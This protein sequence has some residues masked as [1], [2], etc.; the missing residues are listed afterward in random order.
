MGKYVADHYRWRLLRGSFVHMQQELGMVLHHCKVWHVTFQS[1][2]AGQKS[3]VGGDGGDSSTA[4]L[5]LVTGKRLLG[6]FRD[7]GEVA[8]GN[9]SV[10]IWPP[11]KDEMR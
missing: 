10:E 11:L 4:V 3:V 8:L 9:G 7:T 1:A 2:S 6:L 5:F